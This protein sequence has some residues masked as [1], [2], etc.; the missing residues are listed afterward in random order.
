MKN[1]INKTPIWYWILAVIFLLWNLMGVG[2]FFHHTLISDETLQAM[3][4]NEKELYNSYPLWTI[5][6]FA[7]A[8]FGGTIGSIG[9]ILKRKW[10]K[11]AFIISL[12]G[13]IPQM[14]Q[15]LFISNAREVYG[16]GTEIMPIMVIIFGVF[17][18]WFTNLAIKKGWLK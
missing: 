7:F 11:T 9:L 13:I 10:A 8:V 3:P 6:A 17:L 1:I 2:S 4:R 5:I 16:P 15:N 12:G 14:I 18:V